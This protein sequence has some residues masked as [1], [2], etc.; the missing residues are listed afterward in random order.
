MPI[1]KINTVKKEIIKEIH[2]IFGTSEN[3]IK[4]IT[5]DII[6][7]LI[8]TLIEKKKINIKNF[9]SFQII[10]KSERKGRNPKTKEEFNIKSRNSISFKTSKVLKQKMNEI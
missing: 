8:E 4:K 3:N 7:V 6:D 9:G 2:S 5:Q 10:Y 1:T